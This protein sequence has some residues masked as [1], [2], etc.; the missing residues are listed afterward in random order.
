MAFAS[1]YSMATEKMKEPSSFNMME[2]TLFAS[3]SMPTLKSIVYNIYHIKSFFLQS[4]MS[5]SSGITAFG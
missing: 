1:P 2:D 3:K 4:H 5:S